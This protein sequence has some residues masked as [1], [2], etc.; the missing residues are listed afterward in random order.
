VRLGAALGVVVVMSSSS[1]APDRKGK[2]GS[3]RNEIR[4]FPLFLKA[5]LSLLLLLC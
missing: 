2:G 1:R 4:A 3:A 5:L